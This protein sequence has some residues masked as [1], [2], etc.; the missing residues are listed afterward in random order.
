[1]VLICQER[2]SIFHTPV[3]SCTS[4]ESRPLALW[5]TINVGPIKTWECTSGTRIRGLSGPELPSRFT[6]L[7]GSVVSSQQS[8]VIIDADDRHPHGP[9]CVVSSGCDNFCIYYRID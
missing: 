4:G 2:Q 3:N 7:K 9:F 5:I 8:A 6:P 1:M